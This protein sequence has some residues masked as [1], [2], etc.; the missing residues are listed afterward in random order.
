MFSPPRRRGRPLPSP[1]P[2]RARRAVCRPRS[3]PARGHQA[4]WLQSAAIPRPDTPPRCRSS[5]CSTSNPVRFTVRRSGGSQLV[6]ELPRVGRITFRRLTAD[7]GRAARGDRALPRRAR[8]LQAGLRRPRP[9]RAS[10]AS[11]EDHMDRRGRQRS[12]LPTPLS[13][14]DAHQGADTT[15]MMDHVSDEDLVPSRTR[16]PGSSGRIE[17]IVLV[18]LTWSRPAP[19]ATARAPRGVAARAA[20]C[21]RRVRGPSGAASSWRGWQGGYRYQTPSRADAVRRAVRAQ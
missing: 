10:S 14:V 5:T 11:I 9:G 3:G 21:S 13:S 15:V 18:A 4:R 7:L 12:N 6:D 20:R 8:A 19:G 17:A 1:A 16:S 2:R